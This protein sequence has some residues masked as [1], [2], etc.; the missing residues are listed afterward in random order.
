MSVFRRVS[1]KKQQDLRWICFVF[2]SKNGVEVDLSS[3]HFTSP[4]S[5]WVFVGDEQLL[6][7]IGIIISHYQDLFYQ[8]SISWFM[9]WATGFDYFSS[10]VFFFPVEII[11]TNPVIPE[12]RVRLEPVVLGRC[13]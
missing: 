11:K 9:S 13:S 8:T 7:Y 10:E 12:A 5:G 6:S 2:F 4:P 1:T 3:D